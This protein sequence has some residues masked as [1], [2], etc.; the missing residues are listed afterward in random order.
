ML[1]FGLAFGSFGCLFVGIFVVMPLLRVQQMS[2]WVEVPCTILTSRVAANESSDG[3]TY[4]VEVSFAYH[5]PPAGPEGGGPRY[6]STRY[7]A[8]AGVWTSGRAGKQAI[9]K[10][11]PPGHRTTCHVD[12]DAPS[13]AVLRPGL[14]DG[15]A[16][17]LFTLIFPLVGFGTVIG[18]L[19]ASR[20]AR[21]ALTAPSAVQP[22]VAARAH[23]TR[24]PVT[25]RARS[26]VGQLVA[27]LCFAALWNG[28]V[29]TI[30]LASGM[31]TRGSAIDWFPLILLSLFA[32]IGVGLIAAVL[33]QIL[34]LTNPRLQ[35]T[36][37]RGDL[38]PGARCEVAWE[39][40]GN[41]Y[42]FTRIVIALECREWATYTRG[43][44]TITDT[45]VVQRIELATLEDANAM[46]ASRV[47][48]TLD[49]AAPPTFTAAH[50]GIAWYITVRGTIPRWPDLKD[51]FALAVLPGAA[52]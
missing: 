9:V 18:S 38:H 43:T 2:D 20:R 25:L 10:S 40:H 24:G 6:E 52:S 31:I 45:K 3:D 5:Y 12:P 22:A 21:R 51:D 26:R 19:V 44:S 7:D 29:W 33:Y 34:A 16:F 23:G 28:I 36:V 46:L 49:P 48:V 27:I 41:P 17:G 8:G 1:L 30:I 11:L 50:N 39:C 37:D 14:P 15:W 47:A 35:L 4:R 32:L 42:R 13:E